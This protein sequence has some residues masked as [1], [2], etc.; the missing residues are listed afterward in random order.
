MLIK[1]FFIDMG[2]QSKNDCCNINWKKYLTK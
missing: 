1:C 2:N